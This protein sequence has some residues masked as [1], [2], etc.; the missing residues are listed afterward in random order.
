MTATALALAWALWVLVACRPRA[1]LRPA[2]IAALFDGSATVR[3]PTAS[4]SRSW[5]GRSARRWGR[6]RSAEAGVATPPGMTVLRVVAGAAVCL[7]LAT[8]PR[9]CVA[10]VFAWL[11]ARIV[12]RR[13]RRRRLARLESEVD[14]LVVAIGLGLA[15]G[16]HIRQA[17][18]VVAECASADSDDGEA[19][20]SLRSSLARLDRPES[21][22]EVLHAWSRSI[23]GAADEVVAVIVE[24]ERRGTPLAVALR[25]LG[26]DRRRARHLEALEAARRA[27]VAMLLPLVACVL[28]AFVLLTVVPVVVSALGSVR[29]GP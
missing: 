8:D 24:S 23:E 26:D 10:L 12:A 29:T 6:N 25:R 20:C 7:V 18:Q 16:L 14:D 11:A 28:P 19:A 9:W 4:T 22:A 13:R 17:V 27:P 1:R 21:L 2:R 15:A 5:A 3:V